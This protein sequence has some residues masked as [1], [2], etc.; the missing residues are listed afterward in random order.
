MLNGIMVQELN[1]IDDSLQTIFLKCIFLVENLRIVI[2]NIVTK[3][4]IGNKAVLVLLMAC[5]E[6]GDKP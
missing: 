2:N 5:Q 3:G 4:V 6:T 1:D